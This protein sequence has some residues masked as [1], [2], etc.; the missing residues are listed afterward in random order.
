M[1]S[2]LWLF[3]SIPLLLLAAVLFE[4][5]ALVRHWPALGAVLRHGRWPRPLALTH[6]FLILAFPLLMVSGVALYYPPWHAILIPWLRLMKNL[7]V[8]L[9][10]AFAALL[11][12]AALGAIGRPRR[13]RRIDWLI[14]GLLSALVALTGFALWLPGRFPRSWDAVAFGIHG[15]AAWIWFAWIG[16][17]ALLRLFSFQQQHPLNARF[18]YRRR[19]SVLGLLGLGGLATGTLSL[20]GNARLRRS[21]T[22][23][24]AESAPPNPAAGTPHVPRAPVFPAYYTF[25]GS[26]PTID[27]ATYRLRVE[28]LVE[29]P[30]SLSLKELEALGMVSVRRT[31]TC[32]TGWSVPDVLWT[33]MRLNTLLTLAGTQSS[34]THLIFHSADGTYVDELTLEQASLPG[35]ILAWRINGAPLPR[36]GGYPIRLVVPPMYGYKSVKWVDR[37]VV[38]DKGVTGTWE[39]YGYPSN[40]WIT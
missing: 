29:R 10:I 31:F 21:A 27:P 25:T 37:I 2:P 4:R 15:W 39:R 5:G 12:A 20:L 11:L 28:G 24:A 6:G 33:G 13:A 32:V 9:G 7:H 18:D 36:E 23:R 38:T 30:L 3:A 16:F 14:T 19:S 35:V 34:A 22:L 8:W 17:H 26:Y 40:A 1:P